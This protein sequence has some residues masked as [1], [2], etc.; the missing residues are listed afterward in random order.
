MRQMYDFSKMLQAEKSMCVFET[1]FR[2]WPHLY[3][4]RGRAKKF[5][6]GI[7][8]NLDN[9]LANLRTFAAREDSEKHMTLLRTVLQLFGLG[10]IDSLEHTMKKY[11]RQTG[12]VNANE[13]RPEADI[14][15][16][17][18]ML[19]HN[20]NAERPFAV[21]RMY[22]PMYPSISLKNLAWLSPSLVNGTHAPPDRGIAGEIALTADP[23]LQTAIDSLCSVRRKT[24]GSITKFIR[25][26]HAADRAEAVISR[27]RKACEKY[28]TNVR[29]KAKRAELRDYAEELCATSMVTMIQAL[30]IQLNAHACSKKG[31]NK[32]LNDQFHARVSGASPRTYPSK[33][34]KLK[35]T[36]GCPKQCD[37]EYLTALIKA[38]IVEHSDLV[39]VNENTL[40]QLT[41]HFIRGVPEISAEFTNPKSQ[42]TP[43]S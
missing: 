36:S 11:L 42:A 16:C 31:Q 27:K 5:Y 37:L 12:G 19:C 23:I 8:A 21:L 39:G 33:F 3:L 38:M 34:G 26:A 24:A 17:S 13:R 43:K 2:P 32:F 1:G 40:P 18:Q 7:D 35:L 6:N 22:Q 10:I 41:E 14:E 4:D 20:N 29:K 15:R 28:N 25:D 9:D 30:Q